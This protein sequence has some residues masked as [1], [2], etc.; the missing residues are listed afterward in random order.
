MRDRQDPKSFIASI[1]T[2]L[3]ALEA[4]GRFGAL[5][6]TDLASALGISRGKAHRV[7]RT[8][9]QCGYVTNQGAA[10]G[11]LLTRRVAALA[12]APH[13]PGRLAAVATPLMSAWTRGNGWPLSLLELQGDRLAVVATT[14]SLSSLPRTRSRAGAEFPINFDGAGIALLAAMPPR[15][16]ALL[17]A[18]GL[19]PQVQARFAERIWARSFRDA[20]EA[21]PLVRRARAQG[22]Y[23]FDYPFARQRAVCLPLRTEQ[24]PAGV[25]VMRFLKAALTLPQAARGALPGLRALRDAIEERI[26]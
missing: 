22:W 14:D 7:L 16:R 18:A 23:S 21:A 10:G 11:Y 2:G 19:A 9:E 3:R 6:T 20:G 8:L 24:R 26:A 12:A 15:E 4:I 1:D 13:E 5:S 25:L 17:L